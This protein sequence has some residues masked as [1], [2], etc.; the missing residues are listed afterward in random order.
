MELSGLEQLKVRLFLIIHLIFKD[1]FY[2]TQIKVPRNDG[3]G[4]NLADYLAGGMTYLT[5]A[6]GVIV[7]LC[8]KRQ[9]GSNGIYHFVVSPDG[10]ETI[11]HFALPKIAHYYQIIYNLLL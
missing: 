1:D 8:T 3:N 9:T 10:L 6:N 7:I 11:H 4:T 2:C 5:T